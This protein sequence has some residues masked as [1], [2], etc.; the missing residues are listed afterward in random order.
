[1]NIDRLK[2]RIALEKLYLCKQVMICVKL[3]T[4]NVLG[5]YEENGKW[6]VYDTDCVGKVDILGRGNLTNMTDLLYK[7]LV[8]IS[9]KHGKK[10]DKK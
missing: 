9:D 6:V 3:F 1:M 5:L 4:P 2:Y 8:F 10:R 7:R